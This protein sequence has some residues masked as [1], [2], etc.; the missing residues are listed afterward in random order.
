MPFFFR[1]KLSSRA[2]QILLLPQS[3]GSAATGWRS[4]TFFPVGRSAKTFQRRPHDIFEVRIS[5]HS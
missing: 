3:K 4:A 2:A 1:L 5:K